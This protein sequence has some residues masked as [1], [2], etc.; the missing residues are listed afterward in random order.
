MSPRAGGLTVGVGACIG[1]G[2]QA[3]GFM[4]QLEGLILKLF[5]VDAL[6]ATA[7]QQA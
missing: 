7:G 4:L 6:P 3:R 5:A 2:Q 1:H